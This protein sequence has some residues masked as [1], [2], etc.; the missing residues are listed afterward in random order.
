MVITR[1]INGETHQIPLLPDEI[2]KAYQFKKEE[3][4]IQ[5]IR[6]TLIELRSDETCK[7]SSIVD[8]LQNI[9]FYSDII[10]RLE[11]MDFDNLDIT[12]AAEDILGVDYNPLD[13]EYIK[14]YKEAYEEKNK[15]IEK[16]DDN[17]DKFYIRE[18]G[19]ITWIFYNPDG[20]DGF[21]QFQ[22][23]FFYSDDLPEANKQDSPADYIL[24]ACNTTLVDFTDNDFISTAED[25]L[26]KDA[27]L[28]GY[29]ENVFREL[30]D[31]IASNSNK[32]INNNTKKKEVFKMTNLINLTNQAGATIEEM[33]AFI[34]KMSVEEIKQIFNDSNETKLSEDRDSLFK[35]AKVTKELYYAVENT[36]PKNWYDN[37]LDLFDDPFFDSEEIARKYDWDNKMGHRACEVE[38]EKIFNLLDATEL[39]VYIDYISECIGERIESYDKNKTDT[40]IVLRRNSRS[41]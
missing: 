39:K 2:D 1:V 10:Y 9:D 35:I 37:N 4:H 40:P 18:D 7:F 16:C 30:E 32:T 23:N 14:E 25:F 17:L 12:Y 26:K 27:D 34:S 29:G 3:N 5:D 33:S 15:L 11:K 21:G 38:N 6:S 20:C 19:M 41:R 22:I 31:K 24:M 36:S 28:A 8:Y 13:T